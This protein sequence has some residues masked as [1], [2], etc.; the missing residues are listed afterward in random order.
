MGLFK[1]GERRSLPWDLL[2]FGSLVWILFGMFKDVLRF[3]C[4]IR[5]LKAPAPDSST[6]HL[7]I[8]ASC[9]ELAACFKISASGNKRDQLFES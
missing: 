4:I 2:L 9:R 3:A 1:G 8:T 7:Q 5:L 6:H